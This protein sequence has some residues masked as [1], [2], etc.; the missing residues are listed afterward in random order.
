MRIPHFCLL[1]LYRTSFL[2]LLI[3]YAIFADSAFLLHRLLPFP[4][5]KNLSKKTFNLSMTLCFLAALP[6]PPKRETDGISL[7][8]DRSNN[9]SQFYL[10]RILWTIL[11]TFHAENALG[12]VFPAS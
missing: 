4:S 12:P 5:P 2:Q 9:P 11:Y 3:L 6:P 7:S 1:V 10:Q 8:S